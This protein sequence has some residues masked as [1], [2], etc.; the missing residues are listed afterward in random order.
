MSMEP[1]STDT[2]YLSRLHP[3]HVPVRRMRLASI[4]VAGSGFF[5]LEESFGFFVL[6]LLYYFLLYCTFLFPRDWKSRE[7]TR[8]E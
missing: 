7:P 2:V 3:S 1:D 8:P 6:R 4:C 5:H